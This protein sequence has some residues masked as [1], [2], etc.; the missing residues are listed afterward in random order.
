M[1]GPSVYELTRWHTHTRARERTHTHLVLTFLSHY[2]ALCVPTIRLYNDDG[3]TQTSTF[4]IRRLLV[5]IVFAVARYEPDPPGFYTRA[6]RR[7]NGVLSSMN[8]TVHFTISEQSGVKAMHCLSV[9][10]THGKTAIRYFCV[11]SA[12]PLFALPSPSTAL[13]PSSLANIV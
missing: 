7:E 6:E 4:T 13:C 8:R 5:D 11:I 1:S 10:T 9:Q 3:Q 12:V 2:I